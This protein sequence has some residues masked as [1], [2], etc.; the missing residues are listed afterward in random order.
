M[1]RKFISMYIVAIMML[2]SACSSGGNSE[3]EGKWLIASK[4]VGGSPTSYWFKSN[5][6]VI[7]PWEERKTALK[8]FGKYSFIDKTHIKIFMKKGH[9]H[10]IT[11]FFEI[12]KL[13]KNELILRGSI[14]DIKMRRVTT[15]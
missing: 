15:D 6:T 5:G 4:L 7:A 1:S 2:F 11:F 3:I 10:D 12:V 14:Q 8:S 13:D 9:Y